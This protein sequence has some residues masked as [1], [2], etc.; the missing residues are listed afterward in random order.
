MSTRWLRPWWDFI[1]LYSIKRRFSKVQG[2]KCEH[3]VSRL[4]PQSIGLK[5]LPSLDEHIN[6]WIVATSIQFQ[7]LF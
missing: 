1:S 6:G 4:Q 2:V 5:Q 3:V 7:M